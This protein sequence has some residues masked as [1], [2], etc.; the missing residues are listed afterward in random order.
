[1]HMISPRPGWNPSAHCDLIVPRNKT[2][3]VSWDVTGAAEW[4]VSSLS[5][6]L[7]GRMDQ[8]RPIRGGIAELRY[9]L[10]RQGLQPLHLLQ[11]FTSLRL[12]RPIHVRRSLFSL[13]SSRSSGTTVK[14]CHGS[15]QRG[16]FRSSTY[17]SAVGES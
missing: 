15:H 4:V 5:L 3:G 17:G 7:S 12:M 9:E 2:R 11:Q 1:M 10:H 16:I 13:Q 14:P 8:T 6:P